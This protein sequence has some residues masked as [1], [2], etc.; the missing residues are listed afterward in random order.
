MACR[1]FSTFH[2]VIVAVASLYLLFVSDLFDEGSNDELI[3]DRTSTLSDSILGVRCP[4]N[5]HENFHD[6]FLSI[7]WFGLFDNSV[8]LNLYC[9]FPG[10]LINQIIL[11]RFIISL[12]IGQLLSKWYLF[13]FLLFPFRVWVMHPWEDPYCK[14]W[15]N[16]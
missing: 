1:G 5:H 6:L 2:A 15:N 8:M 16:I 12:N 14:T 11:Y 7:H 13:I 3:I 4:R 10:L 9:Q